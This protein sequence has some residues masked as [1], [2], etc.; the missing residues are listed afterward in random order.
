MSEGT[1]RRLSELY[2]ASANEVPAQRVDNAILAAARTDPQRSP[3]TVFRWALPLALAAVVVLSV[4]LVI[5]MRHE[6]S[7]SEY[8]GRG[9]RPNLAARQ[10]ARTE[11][12]D[13]VPRPEPAPQ[14]DVATGTQASSEIAKRSGPEARRHT[15]LDRPIEENSAKEVRASEGAARNVRPIPAAPKLQAPA[16]PEQARTNRVEPAAEG[17]SAAPASSA[18][19]DTTQAHEAAELEREQ[20][21]V[22]AP[23]QAVA[24]VLGASSKRERTSDAKPDDTSGPEQWLKRIE[25]MRKEG[26]HAE[27]EANLAE[28]R[29]RFPKYRL[30]EIQK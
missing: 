16:A 24:P 19:A 20:A 17:I 14:R 22:S 28:F 12:A 8:D 6:G 2:R 9:E 26:K 4:S 3:S 13:A 30:P 29:K 11:Q 1:D 10:P 21:K 7:I 25:R 15:E 27:A 18:R 23:G 5:V